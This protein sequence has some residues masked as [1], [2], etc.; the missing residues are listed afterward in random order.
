MPRRP[1]LAGVLLCLIGVALPVRAA[2][3]K[4]EAPTFVLRVQS[5]DNLM[6]DVKYLAALVG[7]E[8]QAKQLEGILNSMV[9]ENGLAGFDTKR[10]LGVYA[11]FGSEGID[12]TAVGLIPVADEQALL[13]LLTRLNLKAEKGED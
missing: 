3:P 10:P 7:E 5:I 13:G 4:R 12:S 1:I 6:A 9:G 11:T 8:E 2:D